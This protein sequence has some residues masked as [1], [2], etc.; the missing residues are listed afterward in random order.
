MDTHVRVNFKTNCVTILRNF[1]SPV[2]ISLSDIIRRQ[3]L[4]LFLR[5]K[6]MKINVHVMT[7]LFECSF[8]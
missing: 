4:H 7:C 3:V 8:Y 1:L 2:G 5:Q 6:S